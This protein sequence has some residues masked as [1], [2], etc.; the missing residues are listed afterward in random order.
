MS[1]HEED[2]SQ[3]DYLEYPETWASNLSG[4]EDCTCNRKNRG[5]KHHSSICLQ[6]NKP[7][8][9]GGDVQGNA[10]EK[11]ACVVQEASS[12]TQSLQE[13]VKKAVR[14]IICCDKT[15]LTDDRTRIISQACEEYAMVECEKL[16][17]AYEIREQSL[18]RELREA[19]EASK[20]WQEAAME[21]KEQLQQAEDDKERLDEL[22][23][24]VFT[25]REGEKELHFDFTMPTLRAAIDSARGK[26]VTSIV[27][28]AAEYGEQF[29]N[30][31]Q[32]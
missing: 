30:G 17:R 22:E 16:G 20:T 31:D 19:K 26:D 11:S 9:S 21:R 7:N 1:D 5:D 6:A 15:L 25:N 12:P 4:D 14:E 2:L 29:E 13:I 3:P 28:K 10:P 23:H 18:R 27:S 24:R 8:L 32:S